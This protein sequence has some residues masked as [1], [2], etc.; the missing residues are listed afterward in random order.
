MYIDCFSQEFLLHV[1]MATANR[2]P[3]GKSLP[4]ALLSSVLSHF[5]DF[6]SFP[7]TSEA[8]DTVLSE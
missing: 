3:E 6:G 8:V 5:W 2:N 4:I 1:E 7:D